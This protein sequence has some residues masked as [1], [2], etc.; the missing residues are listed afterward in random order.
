MEK[1]PLL[2]ATRIWELSA[3][4]SGSLLEEKRMGRQVQTVVMS[5]SGD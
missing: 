4:D 2:H 5:V 3:C 1:E